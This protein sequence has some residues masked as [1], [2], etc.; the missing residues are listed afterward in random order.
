MSSMKIFLTTPPRPLQLLNLNPTSVPRKRQLLTLI[1]ST[2]PDISLPTTKPPCPWKTMQLSTIRFLHGLPLPR[3]SSFF[4]DLIHIASSPTSKLEFI[5]STSS[6]E[7]TS[8]PSP[9]CEYHGFLTVIRLII[10][11]LHIKGCIFQH[12]E[13][14]NRQSSRSTFSQFLIPMSTGRR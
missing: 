3:P 7:S 9:F 10:T 5:T 13:F 11:F 12:G 4:P 6:H 2:P 1:F 8:R 14:W